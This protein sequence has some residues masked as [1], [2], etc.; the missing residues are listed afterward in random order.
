MTHFAKTVTLLPTRGLLFLH[1][2]EDLKQEFR[3][4]D[5]H[6]IIY[7]IG[8]GHISSMFK[9]KIMEAVWVYFV[10]SI[11]KKLMT[12]CCNKTG[13]SSLTEKKN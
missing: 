6:Y 2:K 1:Y 7:V 13:S 3:K 9:D 5:R 12:F 4:D 10:K 11:A 8:K